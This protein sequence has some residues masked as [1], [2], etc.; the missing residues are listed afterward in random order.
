MQI[1]LS[2]MKKC[3]YYIQAC[4]YISGK[5]NENLLLLAPS[6]KNQVNVE[7][8]GPHTLHFKLLNFVRKS[9]FTYSEINKKM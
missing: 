5:I 7:V 3:N 2:P 9:Y 1:I 4:K 6:G 8:E